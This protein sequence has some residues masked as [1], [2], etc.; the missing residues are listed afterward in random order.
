[1]FETETLDCFCVE[2]S[3]A[4]VLAEASVSLSL[5]R[6]LDVGV[7]QEVLARNNM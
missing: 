7:V 2:H 6:V 5:G 3:W 4:P 1:M